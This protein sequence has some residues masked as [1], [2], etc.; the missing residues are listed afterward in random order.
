MEYNRIFDIVIATN[1]YIRIGLSFSH[2]VREDGQLN[3][4]VKK[5]QILF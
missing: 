3:W 1:G 5:R 4:Y 2:I